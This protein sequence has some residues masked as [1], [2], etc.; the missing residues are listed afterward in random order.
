MVLMFRSLV[1]Q[2][3][4]EMDE[5]EQF[6]RLLVHLAMQESA[7]KSVQKA[8]FQ[9]TSTLWNAAN[10]ATCSQTT[11]MSMLITSYQL[12]PHGQTQ[13]VHITVLRG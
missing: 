5:T 12:L 13:L 6:G 10:A 7:A 2:V 9:T 3:C 4:S 11:T 1:V 8:S